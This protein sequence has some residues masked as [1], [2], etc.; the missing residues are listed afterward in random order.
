LIA[1]TG[2]VHP[3]LRRPWERK[4]Q[5]SPK[6][7]VTGVA[8]GQLDD[9]TTVHSNGESDHSKHH[10]LPKDVVGLTKADKLQYERQ[11]STIHQSSGGKE[12]FEKFELVPV[13]TLEDA[14]GKSMAKVSE[15]PEYQGR[16]RKYAE[17]GTSFQ[18]CPNMS[19]LAFA[20]LCPLERNGRSRGEGLVE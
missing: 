3:K 2:E 15:A 17:Q 8:N 18:C 14:D 1:W 10:E 12:S 4:P 11:L 5:G 9:I 16:F 7:V 19:A 20:T 6:K 13:W